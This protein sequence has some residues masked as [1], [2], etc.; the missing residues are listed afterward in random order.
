MLH[1]AGGLVQSAK[2]MVT[3]SVEVPPMESVTVS[4]KV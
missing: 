3:V 1:E 2:S 4:W